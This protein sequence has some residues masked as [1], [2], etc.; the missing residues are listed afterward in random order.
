[1]PDR[2]LISKHGGYRNLHAY[3]LA[4][5]IH[6]ATVVFCKRFIDPKSRTTDQ[7]VQAARS[8]KQ[9]IAEGSV[10]AAISSKSE[11]KLTGIARGSLVELE[12]DYRDFLRQGGLPIWEKDDIRC[13]KVRAVAFEPPASDPPDKKR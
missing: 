7:M 4:E 3:K 9:N 10:D 6:D 5:V 1:M 8:G 11:L 2:P 13:Q 12:E